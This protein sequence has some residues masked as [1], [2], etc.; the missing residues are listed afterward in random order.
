MVLVLR[1]DLAHV[2]AHERPSRNV[3][4]QLHAEPLPP[5]IDQLV[6]RHFAA[7][8]PLVVALVAAG[9][10]ARDALDQRLGR[11]FSVK[12][13]HGQLEVQGAKTSCS[14]KRTARLTQSSRQ[15]ILPSS[16]GMHEHTGISSC[17]IPHRNQVNPCNAAT[18][19]DPQRTSEY[20]RSLRCT[21]TLR[22]M[23]SISASAVSIERS[24]VRR[25]ASSTSSCS[26]SLLVLP[27]RPQRFR[28]H[29]A[30]QYLRDHIAAYLPF[31]AWD[32]HSSATPSAPAPQSAIPPNRPECGKR[33]TTWSLYV[34]WQHAWTNCSMLICYNSVYLANLRSV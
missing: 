27:L 31:A 20:A 7:L 34:K 22:V 15:P 29:V 25:L 12:S 4:H 5:A 32:A 3:L 18:M 2:L 28:G 17:A 8:D 16:G 24:P 10:V 21:Y 14:S 1:D 11:S 33:A 13:S 19:T 9:T 6:H 26:A 23:I 30:S